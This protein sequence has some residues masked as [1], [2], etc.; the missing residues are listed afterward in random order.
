MPKGTPHTFES[1]NAKIKV[2]G[3]RIIKSTFKGWSKPCTII[4][5]DKTVSEEHSPRRVYGKGY[6]SKPREHIGRAYI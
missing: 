1:A 2:L 3:N 6:K 5:L 4:F